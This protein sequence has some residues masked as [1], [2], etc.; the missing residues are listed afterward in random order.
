VNVRE[1]TL[2]A[3]GSLALLIIKTCMPLRSTYGLF[4]GARRFTPGVLAATQSH[5]IS[6]S[7]CFPQEYIPLHHW[8]A[9]L[10]AGDGSGVTASSAAGSTSTAT[11]N[12]GTAKLPSRCLVNACGPAVTRRVAALSCMSL[13][14]RR[15]ATFF[16]LDVQ[17]HSLCN[18]SFYPPRYGACSLRVVVAYIVPAT[19][20]HLPPRLHAA[21]VQRTARTRARAQ[22]RAN[23]TPCAAPPFGQ[24]LSR[25]ISF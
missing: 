11:H 24:T 21:C 25:R 17:S 6:I 4:V 19:L 12:N 22:R 20:A 9:A 23:C 7:G 13:Q 10:S 2:T 1:L 8:H 14:K 16:R 15:N 3:R 5:S 18:H